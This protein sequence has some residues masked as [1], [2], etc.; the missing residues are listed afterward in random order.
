MNACAVKSGA[1]RRAA[2]TTILLL[3][4]QLGEPALAQ[5][6]PGRIHLGNYS[7]NDYWWYF[8]P[9]GCF[10]VE[11]DYYLRYE[12]EPLINSTPLWEGQEVA[13]DLDVWHSN[14]S[15]TKY[16]YYGVVYRQPN[17]SLV[18]IYSIPFI[19]MQLHNCSPGC[20]P[21]DV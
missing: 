7:C 20:G 2:C 14:C 19:I 16:G 6:T 21:T 18:I 10:G 15:G 12:T 5:G 8:F 13:A 9:G 17:N 11:E 1:V 4:F 3:C